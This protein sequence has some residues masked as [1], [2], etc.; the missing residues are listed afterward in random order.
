[1]EIVSANTGFSAADRKFITVTCPAG[2]IVL[3]G[4]AV[5]IAAEPFQNAAATLSSS[6]PTTSTAWFASAVEVA[7]FP[8]ADTWALAVHAICATPT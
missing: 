6:F 1:M 7:G 4:G 5:S 8:T 3:G 2:K